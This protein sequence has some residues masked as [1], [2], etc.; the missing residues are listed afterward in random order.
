MKCSL[1]V[2]V[3]LVSSA[4]AAPRAQPQLSNVI[5][6]AKE[7]VVQSATDSKCASLCAKYQTASTQAYCP[8]V[9]KAAVAGWA[10][11]HAQ[12]KAT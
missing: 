11:A 1:I 7:E 4:F 5:A 9:C 8:K 2:F 12:Y 10:A 6:G 3:A